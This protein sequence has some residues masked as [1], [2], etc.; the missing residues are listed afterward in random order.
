[1]G[2]TAWIF[3]GQGSQHVGMGRELY[4]RYDE[5][6]RAFE[7]AE[8]ALGHSLR[9]LMFEGP[10]ETLKETRHAQIA[11][12]VLSAAVSRVLLANG[13]SP[14]MVAG[15]SLGEYSALVAGGALD[16]TDALMLVKERAASMQRACELNPGTMGAII[17]L[18]LPTVE[19]ICAEADNG[20][21]DVAN[22]NSP[23]QIVISGQSEAVLAA[24]ETAKK[25]GAKRAIP[26]QVSGAF[27]SRLMRPAVDLFAPFVSEAKIAPPSKTFLPNVSATL[28]NEP[29]EI[30]KN[31]VEQIC[32]PV[33]WQA[34][35]EG[36]LKEGAD[37]FVEVGPGKVLTGLLKRIDKTA[38]GHNAD[39]PDSIEGL[40]QAR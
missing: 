7:E 11:I 35:I 32:S 36:M 13:Y 1:M 4:D 24:A 21:V 37:T 9:R 12:F 30:R 17:G 33:R 10:E 20:I 14:D 34:T 22:I 18:E 3:P 28:T 40:A 5:A 31:L 26:L 27:H 38:V 19:A 2:K 6:R 25:R 15:H 16:F 8:T 23:E 39:T 29:Q